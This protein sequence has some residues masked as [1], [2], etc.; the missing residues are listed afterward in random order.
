[1][2]AA[3]LSIKGISRSFP[4]VKALDNV[5]LE[6][7]KGSCHA[8]V[9]ENGAGKS[10]LGKILAGIYTPDS[11]SV[12]L[13][14]KR[15]S[16]QNSRDAGLSGIG[17]VHQELL[18]CENMTVEENICLSDIP[19]RYLFVDRKRMREEARYAL[20]RVGADIDPRR[21]TG[22]LTVSQQQLVQIASA[23]AHGAEIL[24][25]DE[26]TS[27]LSH[28]EAKR[29]FE[30]I[31]ELK[32]QG[33]TI[34]FVSHRLEEIFAVTD[35]ISVLRD[36]KHVATVHTRE[37]SRDEL[38]KLMVGRSVE[39]TPHFS[40]TAAADNR[41]VLRVR[42]LAV[43]GVFE[44]ISFSVRGG[45]IAGIA[46]L[47][48]AGRTELVEAI[49][50]TGRKRPSGSVEI[51]GS[52]AAIRNVNDAMRLGIGLIPEDRKRHGLVLG[53]KCRENI[54]LS[55]LNSIA[56]AGWINRRREKEIVKEYYGKLDVRPD[57]PEALTSSLSGGNQQKIVIA[58]WLAAKSR[59]L[60]IDEPTRGV[61]I[62][63]RAEIHRLLRELAAEG[64]AI[65]LV[66]SDLPELHAL[67]DRILVMRQG[68]MVKEFSRGGADQE[69]LMRWMA[70][71]SV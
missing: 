11:G 68:R 57:N 6:I 38:V 25:F 69:E 55:I 31:G 48:G 61:D 5:S 28:H 51:D 59:I 12:E 43:K 1:M 71:V 41:E 40:T 70:G 9:G 16:F 66:S 62:A 10:T 45:E 14:G 27:S 30:L 46:G 2:E 56:D 24:I 42:D 18:F 34:V 52:A 17:M 23:V 29:L 54:T 65:L 63:A 47:V 35:T 15:C 3:Y 7:Q 53:M 44:N 8:I 49:F 26:P 39:E 13:A 19:Q 4:G 50:G 21:V 33:V 67:S 58:R 32:G 37:T 22:D 36:G 64:T 60:M 20:A